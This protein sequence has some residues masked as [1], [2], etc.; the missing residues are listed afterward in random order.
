MPKSNSLADSSIMLLATVAYLFKFIKSDNGNDATG[1]I[2]F[3]FSSIILLYGTGRW[4]AGR[5]LKK[6]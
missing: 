2:F 6:N 1:W 5:L 3:W 4:S